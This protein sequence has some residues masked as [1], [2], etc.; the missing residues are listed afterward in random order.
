MHANLLDL[1]QIKE[2]VCDSRVQVRS[3]CFKYCGF[4]ESTRTSFL[5]EGEE[6]IQKLLPFGVIVQ[7]IQLKEKTE[8]Y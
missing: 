3:G 8:T 4:L 2:S 1:T 6:V 7:F 5:H